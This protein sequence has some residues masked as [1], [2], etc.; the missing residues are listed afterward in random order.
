MRFKLPTIPRLRMPARNTFLIEC[1]F[2]QEVIVA[3]TPTPDEHMIFLTGPTLKSLRV[4]CRFAPKPKVERQSVVFVSSSPLGVAQALI[5]IIEQGAEL[6]LLGHSH[7]GRG[8][9]ATTPSGID[10]RTTLE[11]SHG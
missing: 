3:L 11:S 9:S 8:A 4:V 7:P 5:P 1:C 2:L 10:I 6:Q